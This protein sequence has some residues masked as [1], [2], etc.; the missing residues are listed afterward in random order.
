MKTVKRLSALIISVVFVGLLAVSACAVTTTAGAT[1]VPETTAG[2]KANDK[3]FKQPEDYYDEGYTGEYGEY[4]GEYDDYAEYYAEKYAGKYADK[5]EEYADKIED[6]FN[7][8]SIS[9][10]LDENKGV[11]IFFIIATVLYSILPI[12]FILMIVFIV[13]YFKTKKDVEKLNER[14]RA[15]SYQTMH[16]GENP[17]NSTQNTNGGNDR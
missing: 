6:A 16:F 12:I 2:E 3:Q 5:A 7:E 11:F 14:I 1:D 8:R 10:Y 13:M 9:K 17:P 15:Q 4:F